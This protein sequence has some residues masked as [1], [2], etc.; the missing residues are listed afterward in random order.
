MILILVLAPFQQVF[1]PPTASSIEDIVRIYNSGAKYVHVSIPDLNYSNF[2]YYTN[3][4]SRQ[5]AYYYKLDE[6]NG[7]SC[8]FFLIPSEQTNGKADVLELYDAKARFI[9]GDVRFD[10]FLNGFAQ[11]IG[12]DSEALKEISFGFAV[13]QFDY[14]PGLTMI[15][16]GLIIAVL[17]ICV[18]YMIINVLFLFLPH[19]HPSCRRLKRFGLDGEDFSEIDRELRDSL[20]ISAGNIHVTENYIVDIGK[21]NIWMIP[22]FNVVWAYSYGTW[23]PLVKKNKLKYSL[24]IVTSPKAK[25][26]IAGNKKHDVEWVLSFLENN[27][28]HITVGYSDELREKM[29]KLL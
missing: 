11:D 8:V 4:Q 20:L 27:Y 19:L 24:V 29:E 26:T 12:W 23:N 14:R 18:L 10:T 25:I 17:I 5:A 1:N 6:E 2:D 28:T 3:K 21:H 16:A 22:L 15:I 13:S 7:P 9:T